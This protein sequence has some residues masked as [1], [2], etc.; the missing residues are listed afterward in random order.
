MRGFSGCGVVRWSI[1]IGRREGLS[2]GGGQ[3][4]EVL[5]NEGLTVIASH[6]SSSF[7]GGCLR[8]VTRASNKVGVVPGS[9]SVPPRGI[10]VP[11]AMASAM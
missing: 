8:S 3:R 7:P 2:T 1:D 9:R 5:D 6:S 4:W 10:Q 11:L